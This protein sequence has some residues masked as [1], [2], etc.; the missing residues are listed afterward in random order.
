MGN[1]HPSPVTKRRDDDNEDRYEDDK[2]DVGR[3]QERLEKKYKKLIRLEVQVAHYTPR[4][5]TIL[6]TITIILILTTPSS[7]VSKP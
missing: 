6:I 5:A 3:I 7:F 4:Y 2:D 1:Q